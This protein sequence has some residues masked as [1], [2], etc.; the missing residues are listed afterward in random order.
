MAHNFSATTYP[1]KFVSQSSMQSGVGEDTH[2]IG[3][4]RS[5]GFVGHLGVIEIRPR[6]VCKEIFPD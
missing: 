5:D 6:L 1:I 4:V 3:A 2:G